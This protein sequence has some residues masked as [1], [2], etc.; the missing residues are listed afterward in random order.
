MAPPRR[1]RELPEILVFTDFLHFCHLVALAQSH[2]YV[3]ASLSKD[4]CIGTM[5]RSPR[6]PMF[7]LIL[8]IWKS[9]SPDLVSYKPAGGDE[10]TSL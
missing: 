10:V 6:R 7:W 1:S 8:R 2:T 9:D 4:S 3:E 5:N